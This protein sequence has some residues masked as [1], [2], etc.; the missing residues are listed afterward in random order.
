MYALHEIKNAVRTRRK[1]IGLSQRALAELSGLS[2]ATINQLEQG[3]LNDLSLTRI[4]AVL[5]AIGLSLVVTPAHERS[6]L[7]ESTASSPLEQAARMASVSY[8]GILDPQVLK[9]AL[10]CGSFPVEFSAHMS[11][12]LDEVPV[13]LLSKVVEQIHRD[14]GISR[15]ALWANMRSMAIN[16]KTTRRFW[17]V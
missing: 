6:R 4:A 7:I 16:F 8:K 15:Q 3:T 1:D 5:E 9:S 14:S 11:A 13:S 12:L 10:T 17:Y 2:R